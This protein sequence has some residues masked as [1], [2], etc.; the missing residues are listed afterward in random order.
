[1]DQQ[2]NV[3]LENSAKPSKFMALIA[4]VIASALPFILVKSFSHKHKT[5]SPFQQSAAEAPKLTAPPVL[6]K[7]Q[8]LTRE[9]NAS[10]PESLN[11]NVTDKVT[12]DLM[13][14]PKPAGIIATSQLPEQKTSPLEKKIP[15][16][17][18]KTVKTQSG[19][20][21]AILFKRLGLSAQNLQTIM[22][23]IPQTKALTNLKPN[24]QLQ[25]LIKQQTLEKMIVPFTSMQNLVIYREADH[26]KSKINSRKMDSHNHYVT[27]TIQG[28]LYGTA[29]RNNIPNKLIQQMTEI[30][31]WDINF[32]KDVRAGDRF[33]IIY[34]AF[35]IDD[36]LVGT[37]DIVAV[38]YK[39]RERTYQ[40]IH[41]T[42][43][44][45]HSEYYSPEGTS[46]KKAFDR[47]PLRFSHI[48]STF[49]LGRYHPILHY[50]RA[51][52]GVDLAAPIGTPIRA[53]GSGRI[54]IIGRQSG[55]G[56]MIKINHNNTYS[57]V[58]GHML[59]FQKGLAKGDLVKRGEIIGYV[60]QTGLAT[61]PHCHYEFHINRQP[62]NPTTV[63]LPRG[64]PIPVKE[65]VA[66]KA[67]A[68]TLLSQ[69]KL[70]EEARLAKR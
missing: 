22:Q 52:K 8:Q 20:S 16:R 17:E 63:S 70:F 62:K 23:D 59:R 60:G 44:A 64:F 35:Y 25:L 51:H 27:A 55:Y 42:N 32:A 65:M 14:Q 15:G 37:G 4:L 38:S 7:N 56:N 19:D 33:T 2:P 48:S 36:K 50:K 12:P 53:T 3:S 34:K 6:P 31:T 68:A 18:W 1:M 10:S 5:H 41:Y 24:Q 11:V 26:Y 40:A 9:R 69:L 28:S 29:K 58:Y 49:S 21:L 57:T 45:G 46:L 66:F 39:N 61:G 13:Q 30:F 67:N 47:Y 54:E 43:K